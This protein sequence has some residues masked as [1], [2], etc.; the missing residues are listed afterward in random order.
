VFDLIREAWAITRKK[1]EEKKDRDE[2]A[3]IAKHFND[4]YTYRKVYVPD[5]ERMTK[6]SAAF[7]IFPNGGYAWMCPDCNRVHLPIESSAFSGL[8]YPR[9]CKWPEGHRHYDGIRT[10]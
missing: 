5:M 7:G 8:Q 9:C 6:G 4:R 3:R 2:M 10:S 1:R